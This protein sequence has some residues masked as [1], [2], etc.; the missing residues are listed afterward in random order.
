[1][2]KE[3]REKGMEKWENS[4][5]KELHNIKKVEKLFSWV[6]FMMTL[7]FIIIT[8][9]HTQL[10]VV[11]LQNKHWPPNQKYIYTLSQPHM[12]NIPIGTQKRATGTITDH[13]S[14]KTKTMSK[15]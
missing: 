4:D 10:N 13:I 7:A 6:G 3:K 12:N 1:M 15:M 14:C 5:T 11:F 2:T 9:V 8:L